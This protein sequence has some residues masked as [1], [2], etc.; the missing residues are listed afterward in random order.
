MSRTVRRPSHATIVAYLAL[1]LAIGGT[2][3][4]ATQLPRNSVTSKQ[5]RNKSLKGK[6]VKSDALTGAQVK[7]ATLSKVADSDLLDGRDSSDFLSA[8]DA[9]GFAPVGAIR[10]G[11]G[12]E[13]ATSPQVILDYPDLGIRLQTDGDSDQDRSYVLANTR[14][15]GRI[16]TVT[17]GSAGATYTYPGEL[18]PTFNPANRIIDFVTALYDDPSTAVHFS[19][20]F[21]PPNGVVTCI[22]IRTDLVD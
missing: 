6:D 1:M 3:F 20:G 8:A 21:V 10:S 19:C 13:T 7:E 16:A 5:V 9:A 17:E 4:A 14:T 18:S 2:A 22:G 11:S 15:S 12:N